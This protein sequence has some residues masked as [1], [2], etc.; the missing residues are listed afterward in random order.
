MLAGLSDVTTVSREQARL[1]LAACLEVPRWMDV[2]LAGRPYAGLGAPRA[3]ATITVRAEEVRRA[4]VAHPRIGER[5][6]GVS[7]PEQSGV[8]SAAAQRFLAAN[9]EYEQRFGQVF[10]VRASGRTGPELLA[11]L[12]ERRGNDPET[13]LA[14]AGRDLVEIAVLRL[15][16]TVHRGG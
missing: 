2:V 13:E 10:L 12:R 11:I 1:V 3:R 7:C 5:A 15:A 9:A 8:D 4:M 14:V 6:S 16:E